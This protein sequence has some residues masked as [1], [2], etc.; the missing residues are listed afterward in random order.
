MLAVGSIILIPFPYSDLSRIKQRP[1]LVLRSADSLGDLLVIPVTSKPGW[2]DALALTAAALRS[3][4]L[5]KPSWARCDKLFTISQSAVISV[6][7]E[8]TAVML[9]EI[10]EQVCKQIGCRL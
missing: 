1:A 4:S 8:V 5:P 6:C 9:G 10:M 2:P 3:G 7:A